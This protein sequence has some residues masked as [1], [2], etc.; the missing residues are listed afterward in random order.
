MRGGRSLKNV[1][2]AHR[3]DSPQLQ[4]PTPFP[5]PTRLPAIVLEAQRHIVEIRDHHDG[6][7]RRYV[8]D[9]TYDSQNR[10]SYVVTWKVKWATT[11]Q[12]ICTGMHFTSPDQ[13]VDDA[14]AKIEAWERWLDASRPNLT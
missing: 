13:A 1:T 7:S 14:L 6:P 5:H 12:E 4:D 11:D 9:T 2:S 10:Y 3:Q 8:I